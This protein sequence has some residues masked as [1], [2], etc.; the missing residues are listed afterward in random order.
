MEDLNFLK[1][2]EIPRMSE[3]RDSKPYNDLKSVAFLDTGQLVS[4]VEC[5]SW[6]NAWCIF[7]KDY[8]LSLAKNRSLDFAY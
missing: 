5:L 7:N 6:P 1:S 8:W 3:I 2:L 4:T